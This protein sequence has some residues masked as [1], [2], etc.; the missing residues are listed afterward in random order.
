MQNSQE[1]AEMFAIFRSCE[2]VNWWAEL[3]MQQCILPVLKS[4][5]LEDGNCGGKAEWILYGG[6]FRSCLPF[7]PSFGTSLQT[8]LVWAFI[9]LKNGTAKW[10]S[11][12]YGCQSAGIV[13]VI[14]KLQLLHLWWKNSPMHGRLP[15]PQP[16]LPCK[17]L[18]RDRDS[19]ACSVLK[20]YSGLNLAN[21]RPHI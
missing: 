8:S 13:V 4:L 14:E 2:W 1:R 11:F 16:L 21:Q 18:Q 17:C 7:Q 19:K 12:S 20:V 5:L 9:H 15:M 6:E 10:R 3:C